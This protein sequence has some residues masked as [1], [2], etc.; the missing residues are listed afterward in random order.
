MAKCRWCSSPRIAEVYAECRD[1]CTVKIGTALHDGYVPTDLGLGT[2]SDAV[3][4]RLCL[5]CGQVQGRWPRPTT[6]MEHDAHKARAVATEIK[7]RAKNRF[8]K[9]MLAFAI[10]HD[11]DRQA[12]FLKLTESDDVGRVAQ[13]LMGLQAD[14]RLSALVHDLMDMLV[15]W[16]HYGRLL[17]LMKVEP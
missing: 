9:E 10:E 13:G 16:E 11:A 14:P 17:T 12:V 15:E 8:G 1:L 5:H 2:D 4:M 7:R 6:K 3:S